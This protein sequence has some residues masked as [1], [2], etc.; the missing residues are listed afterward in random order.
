MWCLELKCER[1][2][3]RHPH[4]RDY[5]CGIWGISE[6]MHHNIKCKCSK[7][8]MKIGNLILNH[9]KY[10]VNDTIKWTTRRWWL[11]LS[12]V[13]KMTT[14]QQNL[15]VENY[16]LTRCC[17]QKGQKKVTNTCPISN[18]VTMNQEYFKYWMQLTVQLQIGN[19]RTTMTTGSELLS[20]LCKH[21]Q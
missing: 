2:C 17:Q 9:Y 12:L 1:F 4:S 21:D 10:T 11:K 3:P 18:T 5:S 14:E 13:T 19:L 8:A 20:V 16:I 7:C 6:I 15:T